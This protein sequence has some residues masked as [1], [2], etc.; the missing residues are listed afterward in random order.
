MQLSDSVFD[1]VYVEYVYVNRKIC[2]FF[3]LFIDNTL[4]LCYYSSVDLIWV[5]SS[6]G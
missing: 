6:V 1:Y 2:I 3:L 4:F 5:S